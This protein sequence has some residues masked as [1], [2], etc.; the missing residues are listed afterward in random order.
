MDKRSEARKLRLELLLRDYEGAREE[1]RQSSS[2]MVNLLGAALVS[3]LTAF[4]ILNSDPLGLDSETKFWAA[5]LSPI[6]LLLPTGY[7]AQIG[8]KTA[9]R[10]YYLR[11]LERTIRSEMN[12]NCGENSADLLMIFHSRHFR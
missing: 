11:V 3:A 4:V 7:S 2:A 12:E 5:V 8:A 9:V 6:V 1:E 10:S